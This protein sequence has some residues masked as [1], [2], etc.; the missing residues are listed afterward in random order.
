MD[1]DDISEPMF[2]NLTYG[3]FGKGVGIR[4]MHSASDDPFISEYCVNDVISHEEFF[5][6]RRLR[7]DESLYIPTRFVED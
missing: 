2:C 3:Q 6:M 1:K 4:I 7:R 5:G